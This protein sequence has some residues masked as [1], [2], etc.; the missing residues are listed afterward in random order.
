[1]KYHSVKT[2]DNENDKQAETRNLC[3]NREAALT[4]VRAIRSFIAQMPLVAG[5]WF[6]TSSIQD[7]HIH[8]YYYAYSLERDM[9]FFFSHFILAACY[10]ASQLALAPRK[11]KKI[12]Q[13]E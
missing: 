1:M 10:C 4:Y 7:V 11:R 8:I 13:N 12:V 6:E 9:G 2:P 3:E 5:R